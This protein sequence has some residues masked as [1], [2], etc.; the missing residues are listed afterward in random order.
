GTQATGRISWY[1]ISPRHLASLIGG[2]HSPGSVRKKDHEAHTIPEDTLM[3][4]L[5]H[6]EVIT[7]SEVVL[8]KSGERFERVS[9]NPLKN[10]YTIT[11][12]ELTFNEQNAGQEVFIT[13]FHYDEASLRLLKTGIGMEA[14]D[15]V[16]NAKRCI[17]ISP[18]EVGALSGEAGRLGFDFAI[19][20]IAPGDLTI[21]FSE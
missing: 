10:E 11:D 19:E 3:I 17:R 9:E 4:T 16:I 20:N 15:I 21:Y 1:D 13:Y 6:S 18:L 12:N 7:N 5:V 14:G 8:A 2:E